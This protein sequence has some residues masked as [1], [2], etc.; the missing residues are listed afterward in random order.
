MVNESNGSEPT[1]KLA[2]EGSKNL[3]EVNLPASV[4]GAVVDESNGSK[5]TKKF[6]KEG[7]TNL[8]EDE[9]SREYVLGAVVD[10]SNGSEPTKKCAGRVV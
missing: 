2:K 5:P 1:K 3:V 4:L 8:I 10:E 7:S 9:P 6:A